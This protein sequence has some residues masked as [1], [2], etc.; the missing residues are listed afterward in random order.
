MTPNPP[1][2]SP[3]RSYA[4]SVDELERIPVMPDAPVGLDAALARR[5]PST[6]PADGTVAPGRYLGLYA[7][8]VALFVGPGLISGS[9]VH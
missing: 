4:A 9:I 3:T 7:K 2:T 5:R 6:P 1:T 8:Y